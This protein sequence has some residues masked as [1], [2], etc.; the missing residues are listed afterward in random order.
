MSRIKTGE[1]I[2]RY[3]AAVLKTA[4]RLFGIEERPRSLHLRERERERERKEAP[5]TARR[6][7][8]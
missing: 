8:T 5:L 2:Y 1:F 3:G 7:D 4:E 6:I